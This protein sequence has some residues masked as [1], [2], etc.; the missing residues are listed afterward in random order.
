[1]P[2]INEFK[3]KETFY[4]EKERQFPGDFVLP[5]SLFKLGQI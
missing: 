3:V 5:I 4:S 2:F 1:M